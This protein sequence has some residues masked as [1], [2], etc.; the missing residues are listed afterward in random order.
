MDIHGFPAGPYQTNCYLFVEANHVVV[1]DPG[2]HVATTLL[3]V[4]EEK[5]W[6]IDAIYLTHGHIDHMRDAG[7]LAQQFNIPVYIHQADA[8]MLENGDGVSEESKVLFDAQ[9]L[10][11][12]ADLRFLQH[13]MQLKIHQEPITVKHAPGHSP[14]SCLLVGREF[15]CAGDVL[16]KGSIGR[17]DLPDSSPTDMDHTLANV[18]MQLPDELQ[19]LPGHGA[20]TTMRH[21][22]RTNP[23]LAKFR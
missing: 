3:P 21:E 6:V 4:L 10:V 12:I 18:V 8:F 16:F 9:G 1:I 5:Q 13:D 22:K 15:V 20:V 11:P 19:V 2:M 23:F 14:G 17:T 7:T